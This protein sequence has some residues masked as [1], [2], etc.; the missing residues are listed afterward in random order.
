MSEDAGLSVWN[1]VLGA[2]FMLPGVRVDRESFLRTALASHLTPDVLAKAIA[3]S[4]AKAG[5]P[6]SVIE[7][8]AKGSIK[9]HRVGVSA[10]SAV[11]GLPGGWWVAGTIPADLA[12]Y[13]WH[14]TVVLQKLAYLHSW[15]TLI[16]N[17]SELDDETKL[18]F[19]LFIGVMLGAQGAN[20]GLAQ[21]AAAV[22][23][24]VA[25]TLPRAALTKH[26]IYKVAKEVAKW[27]GTSLTKK[28]FGELVGR[29]IPIV[30]GAVA[31]GITW[32]AFGRG[33]K[34]LTDHLSSLPL[35]EPEANGGS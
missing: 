8:I 26:A 23:A 34:R 6:K 2:A 35:A 31:G 33:A 7:R 13:F 32:V 16:Q 19:T 21:L 14:A 3:T 17:D 20:T 30:G 4:P 15:P 24:E 27:I 12:Q 11:G 1:K 29:T 18:T 25:H 10:T 22:G 28:K 5:V 9:W